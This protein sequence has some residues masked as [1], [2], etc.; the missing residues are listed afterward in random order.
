MDF[1]YYGLVLILPLSAMMARRIPIGRTLRMA[2]IWIA[3][4]G[5][6][7]IVIA[8]RDRLTG[9]WPKQSAPQAT[10]RIPVGSDGHYWAMVRINGT[11]RRM[12]VDSGATTTALSVVTARAAGLDL[13][14]SPFGSLIETANGRV[15]ADHTT[16]AKLAIG[17]ITLDDVGADV[18]PAFGDQ[19]IIGMNV[20]SR[21]RG[22]RVEQG[23]LVLNPPD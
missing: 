20:L 10:V 9:W 22:W 7:Y 1:V 23:V 3:I 12:L 14:E 5:T 2:L 16:I 15:T 13:K 19:D 21:L 17:P 8:Q 18:S 11:E 6:A 4:F